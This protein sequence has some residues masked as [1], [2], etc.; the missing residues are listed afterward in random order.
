MGRNDKRKYQRNCAFSF[1]RKRTAWNKRKD[2]TMTLDT[3]VNLAESDKGSFYNQKEWLEEYEYGKGMFYSEYGDDKNYTSSEDNDSDWEE[4]SSE[5]DESSD[6]NTEELPVEDKNIVVSLLILRRLICSSMV[7]KDCHESVSLIE[8]QQY[9][10]GLA[11]RFKIQCTSTNCQFK[12]PKPFSDMTRKSGQFYEIN[13][14]FKLASRLIGR[15][16]SAATKMTSVL[17]LERPVSKKSWKN[18]HFHRPH[19]QNSKQLKA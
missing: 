19:L 1:K 7:C 3:Q 11:R 16:Y 8:D 18:I 6:S 4:S 14:A 5:E 9:S 10:A 12:N 2:K 13:R 15:G 17:N